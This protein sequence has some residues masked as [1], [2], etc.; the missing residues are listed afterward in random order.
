MTPERE[1]DIRQTWDQV[2]LQ[3]WGRD[4]PDHRYAFL[5]K[6][7]PRPIGPAQI[8]MTEVIAEK[9]EFVRHYEFDPITGHENGWIECE[10]LR[11]EEWG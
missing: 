2:R 3:W 7:H 10:G 6:S 4:Q 9:L 5:D 8:D 1:A 11:L